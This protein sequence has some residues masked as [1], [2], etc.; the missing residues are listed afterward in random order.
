MDLIRFIFITKTENITGLV[1]TKFVIFLNWFKLEHYIFILNFSK[2]RDKERLKTSPFFI[3][4][5]FPTL[6]F[7]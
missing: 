4:L 1:F 7:D 5:Q 2:I 3:L 6:H